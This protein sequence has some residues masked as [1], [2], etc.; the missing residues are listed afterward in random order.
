MIFV[1]FIMPLPLSVGATGISSF[2]G[3]DEVAIVIDDTPRK[4][5]HS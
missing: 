4:K 1:Y 5:P 2:C 3:F